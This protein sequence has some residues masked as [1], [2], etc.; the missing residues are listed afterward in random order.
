MTVRTGT[1]VQSLL[2]VLDD[3][4][5]IL[6]SFGLRPF[7]VFVRT[8]TWSGGFVGQGTATD[9]TTA[10]TVGGG[11]RPKVVEVKSKD[12]V[13]SGGTIAATRYKVGPL[14]PDYGAGGTQADVIDPVVEPGREVHFIVTGPGLATDG[15]LCKRVDGE[16]F[17]PFKWFFFLERLGQDA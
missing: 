7:E 16:G 4:R 13:A 17:S 15:V 14:T 12:V 9:E 10:I 2:P 5:G 3:A 8:R 1:L 11:L 6:D